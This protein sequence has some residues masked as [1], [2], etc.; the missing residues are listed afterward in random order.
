MIFD[1]EGSR[2]GVAQGVKLLRRSP[3]RQE[4]QSIFVVENIAA[5]IL[6][7]E[8]LGFQGGHV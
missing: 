3:E 7:E 2:L 4:V 1:A 6:V 8:K 5:K